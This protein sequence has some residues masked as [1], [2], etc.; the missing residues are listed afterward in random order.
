MLG[1]FPQ[2]CNGRADDVRDEAHLQGEIPQEVAVG[3]EQLQAGDHQGG[4]AEVQELQPRHGELTPG[5]GG[6]VGHLGAEDW[7]L[8]GGPGQTCQVPSN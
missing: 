2:T 5:E 8:H 3:E 7:L 4:T 1:F 6:Q